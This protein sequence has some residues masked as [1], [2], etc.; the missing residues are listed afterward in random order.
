M[1]WCVLEDLIDDAHSD[2]RGRQ[3]AS[4]SVRRLAAN[5]GVSKDTTARALRRLTAGELIEAVPASR[6]GGGRFGGG[7]YLI[8]SVPSLMGG[9]AD[10]Q[11]AVT[12]PAET[13]AGTTQA[14]RQRARITQSSQPSLFDDNDEL[15]A[16]VWPGTGRREVA[17]A[18]G[19]ESG[20]E[21]PGREDAGREAAG[22]EAAGREAAAPESRAAG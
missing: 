18:D 6:A 21:E 10:L 22:R 4:S 7:G 12:A 2:E 8:R 11:A 5:L 13:S 16:E 9:P 15:A 19:A 3:V 17:A 1:A 20:R 14:R